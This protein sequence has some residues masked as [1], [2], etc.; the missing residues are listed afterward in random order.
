MAEQSVPSGQ[1]V[2]F[3]VEGHIQPDQDLAHID[4]LAIR[5]RSTNTGEIVSIVTNL[6]AGLTITEPGTFSVEVDLQFNLP[7]G[8]YMLE[9]HPYDGRRMRPMQQSL[10]A[11]M[12]VTESTSFVGRYQ[13]NPRM[14]LIGRT[15][16]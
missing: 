9:A 12:T 1:R 6:R 4:P 2:A 8:V 3:R 10:V 7:A 5:V 11:S 16:D 14:R 15:P 13:L